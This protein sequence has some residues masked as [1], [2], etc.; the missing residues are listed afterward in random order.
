MMSVPRPRA[1]ALGSL[2]TIVVLVV[3]LLVG[4]RLMYLSVQH[5]A[6]LAR[7]TAASVG[8]SFASKIEPPLRELAKLAESRAAAA[9]HLANSSAIASLDSLPPSDNTFW[10]A[11]DDTVLRAPSAE[12]ATA[13][14]IASEWRS[15]ES[16]HALEDSAFL[17]PLRLGSEWIVAARAPLGPRVAGDV[18]PPRAWSVA[19]GDL[20]DLIA[21]SHLARLIDMGYDFQLSQIMPR[22]AQPRIFVSSSAEPLS[23][24]VGVRIRLPMAAAIAGSYLEVAIRPRAGWYPASLLA[25]DVGLLAFMTWLLAFG[26]HDLSHALQRSRAALKAARRRLRTINQQLASEMQQRMNLQE[27]FAHA[28]FHDAFTGLPNRRYFMDR[29]DRAMRDVR[30]KQR[31]RIAVII[32][33]ITRFKLVNDML[34]HTAGDELMVQAA[35]RFEKS[36]AAFEGVLARWGGDQFAL[37]VLKLE[38]SDEALNIA[39]LLREELRLPFQL[40]RHQLIVAASVGVTY[41]DSGQQRAEDVVR[42]ADIALS[43]AKRNE[44]AR[45][46]LYS[47]SMG[48]QA[49]NLVS[50]EADLHLALEKHQLRLLLQPIVD[51]RTY[52]MVGAEA[53]LRW[54]HPVESVLAPDRFLRIAEEAGLMAPITRWVILRVIRIAGD[55]LR[56]LPAGQKFYISINLSPAALRDPGLSEYVAALLRE[57]EL[58]PSVLKFELTE[59]ALTGNVGAARETLE[60]LHA[61]GIQLMLDDFGTGYS[62]LSN[63]QLFP[64]DFVKIERPFVNLNNADQANTGMM[65]AMVQMAASLNLTAIAEI[66]EAEAAAKALQQMGCDFGQ[67]YY[68]SEPIDA[69]LALQRLSSQEPFK[70]HALPAPDTAEA[71]VL[72]RDAS[73]TVIVAPLVDP[74]P[75]PAA[76]PPV[77]VAPATAAPPADPSPTLIV[78]P[79]P[80]C[81]PTVMVPPLADPSPT[82]LVP[83][84]ADPSPTLVVPPLADPSPTLVVPP[85]ADPSPTLVVPPLADPSPTAAPQTA[86]SAPTAMVPPLADPSPTPI[87]P[88]L[89]GDTSQTAIMPPLQVD[90]STTVAVPPLPDPSEQTA[91][92]QPAARPLRGPPLADD[93]SPTIMMPADSFRARKDKE[94]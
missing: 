66:I 47:P 37:L 20:D 33:D 87:V 18:T 88:P 1:L 43:V 16:A 5:H 92:P 17:G 9:A 39:G 30:T 19:Y 78:Q 2:P 28:R 60:R 72:P 35:R 48:G 4:S 75:E 68:F 23:D 50:L 54:R 42:E 70:P 34:G 83:P 52:K 61:M 71:P 63:L 14:G 55:W 29:L 77:D 59:A 64:F 44:T 69:E 79:L 86:D 49:A 27:T 53:L 82:L 89:P 40:R 67:G 73:P 24:A 93:D 8:A 62:S 38:S 26:T 90:S 91:P 41:V 6:A 3:V 74:A 46:V 22:S 57:A 12:N 10:M 81:S 58:P 31:P 80:D 76:A 85:L 45:I 15:A 21:D 65:A 25:S 56:R 11:P 84:L 36:A 94:E 51:L 32:V 7:D 13:S